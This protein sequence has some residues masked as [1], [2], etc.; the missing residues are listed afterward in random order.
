M[1]RINIDNVKKVLLI[2]FVCVLLFVASFSRPYKV[3]ALPIGAIALGTGAL[4]AIVAAYFATAGVQLSGSENANGNFLGN[5][6]ANWVKNSTGYENNSYF[7]NDGSFVG[8]NSDLSIVQNEDSG[9]VSFIFGKD[10]AMWLE[11]LKTNF[12]SSNN[13]TSSAPVNLY[14][15]EILILNSTPVNILPYSTNGWE[16]K[17]SMPNVVD[18]GS[19][20]D[21]RFRVASSNG[22]FGV[23]VTNYSGSYFDLSYWNYSSSGSAGS[24][25][26][27]SYG[28]NTSNY[29]NEVH[30]ISLARNSLNQ[31]AVYVLTL[32]QTIP[33]RI[34][35]SGT[36]LGVLNYNDDV[37]AISVS[38]ELTDGYEDFED[39]INQD[40]TNADE[41]EV[42][43]VDVGTFPEVLDP[44]ALVDDI[45]DKI[46]DR[47]LNPTYDGT[48][49][50]TQKAEEEKEGDKPFVPQYPSDWVVV[51]GLQSFFPFCIPWDLAYIIG[52]LQADPVAPNFTWVMNFGKYADPYTIH[53]DLA[54]FETVAI[55]F[56]TMIVFLFVFFLIKKSRDL[57]RG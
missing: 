34:V 31:I 28:G 24:V 57:I 35:T 25:T 52:M 42:A 53:I 4:G 39:A 36:Q 55:V 16:Y 29:L 20:Q 5:Y 12:V 32:D 11:A 17:G 15:D 40:L 6:V 21:Q 48:R 50:N 7:D 51:N 43:V 30:G 3:Q 41:E 33:N 23:R 18:F 44:T 38:G 26:R 56:R 22:G 49:E 14:S 9:L 45:L 54:P 13:L 27:R 1:K 2:V 10:F 8:S 46:I 47:T 19:T 37:S